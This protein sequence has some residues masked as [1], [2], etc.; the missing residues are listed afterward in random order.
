MEN[1]NLTNVRLEALSGNGIGKWIS[2]C[3]PNTCGPNEGNCGPDYPTVHAACYP[4]G[5]PPRCC[6]NECIGGPGCHPASGR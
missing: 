6:P 5:S 3:N 2:G 1:L 4:D